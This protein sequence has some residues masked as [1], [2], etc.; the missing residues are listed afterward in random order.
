MLLFVCLLVSLRNLV[1]E[2]LD[3]Y[4]DFVSAGLFIRLVIGIIVG[5]CENYFL[6]LKVMEDKNVLSFLVYVLLFVMD[7]L[8]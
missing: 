2:I 6:N 4:D 8:C 5:V 3:V 7:V 1:S